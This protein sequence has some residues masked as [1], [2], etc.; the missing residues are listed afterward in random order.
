MQLRGLFEALFEA[1]ERKGIS[2]AELYRRA[3]LH[4]SAVSRTMSNEDC[5]FSTLN[6]LLEAGGLKFVV[7]QDSSAAD[8][9]AKGTLF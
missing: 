6:R 9:L 2:K 7:V 5:R 4:Q 1:A 3:G 8:K